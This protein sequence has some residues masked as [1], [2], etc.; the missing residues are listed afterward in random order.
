MD[1]QSQTAATEAAAATPTN[2]LSVLESLRVGHGLLSRA[3]FHRAIQ[4]GDMDVWQLPNNCYALTQFGESIHGKALNILT[5]VGAMEHA[6]AALSAIEMIAKRNEC[7][8]VLSVGRPGWEAVA[9][10]AGY[11]V[12]KTILMRKTL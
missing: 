8:V 12:K 11:E 7:S 1:E 3:Q 2:E 10:E 6:L 9:K 4:M 5:T